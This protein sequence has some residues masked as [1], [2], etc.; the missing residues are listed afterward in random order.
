MLA[1]ME[2]ILHTQDME[3]IMVVRLILLIIIPPINTQPPIQLPT[4]LLIPLPTL[5]PTLQPTLQPTPVPIP[6]SCHHPLLDLLQMHIAL[7][8]LMMILM[9]LT[10]LIPK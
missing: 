3:V 9:A 1:H 6:L 8:K 5:V 4:L 2:I 10:V 7:L